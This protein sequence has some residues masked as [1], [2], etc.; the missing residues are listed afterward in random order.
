MEAKSTA[1]F[2]QQIGGSVSMID[3]QLS[4]LSDDPY[5][6]PL[7]VPKYTPADSCV[8]V[9]SASRSTLSKARSCGR[10]VPSGSHDAPASRVR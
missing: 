1:A 8:S 3:V 4:P 2:T 9:V 10:P 7:R 5:S 6:L